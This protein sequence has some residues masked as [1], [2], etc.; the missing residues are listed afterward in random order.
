MH[1]PAVCGGK[2]SAIRNNN[3]AMSYP[4]LAEFV[5][6]LSSR[7][8]A[9]VSRAPAHRPPERDLSSND[10]PSVLFFKLKNFWVLLNTAQ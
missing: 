4:M 7:F 1:K 5:K 9:V 6:L 8:R 3:P 10:L 2:R